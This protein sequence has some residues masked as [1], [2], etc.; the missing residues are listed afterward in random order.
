MATLHIN[1]KVCARNCLKKYS[2]SLAGSVLCDLSE[3]LGP[4]GRRE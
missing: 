4:E 2:R 3:V 1:E